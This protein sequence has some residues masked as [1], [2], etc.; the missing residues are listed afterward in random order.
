MC[1]Y[2]F[3]SDILGLGWFLRGLAAYQY[4]NENNENTNG[5]LVLPFDKEEVPVVS[6]DTGQTK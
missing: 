1:D 3:E 5:I 2:Q 6:R 4:Q